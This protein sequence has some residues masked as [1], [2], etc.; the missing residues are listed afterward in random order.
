[1]DTIEIKTL[2]KKAYD[3]GFAHEKKYKGCAQCTIAAVLE[4]L[5][6]LDENLFRAASGLGGGGGSTCT[7]SCGGL[8]GGILVFGHFTGRRRE[9]F[10]DDT[11]NKRLTNTMTQELTRRFV[12]TYNTVICNE[13]H[14][15]LFDRTFDLTNDDDKEQFDYLG[16][17]TTKCTS[18]VGLA[19]QW[20]IEILFAHLDESILL[21]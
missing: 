15:N 12:E 16:A 3:L 1:M 18:V 13:I 7:G 11:K 21:K 9:F 2:A 17:H 4:T 10:H 19:S 5:G 6:Q 8:L 20:T 14:L